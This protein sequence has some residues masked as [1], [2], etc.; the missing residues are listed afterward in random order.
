M[1]WPCI[2]VKTDELRRRNTGYGVGPNNSSG[3]LLKEPPQAQGVLPEGRGAGPRYLYDLKGPPVEDMACL[4]EAGLL[5]SSDVVVEI[6]GSEPEKPLGLCEAR[7]LVEVQDEHD[8]EALLGGVD[9]PG[10][11]ELQGPSFA[12]L[13]IAS[14]RL[15]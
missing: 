13:Q 14:L 2:R 4:H 9:A 8:G 15:G 3:Y 10:V 7:L 12:L 1:K 5:Q 11:R 6:P